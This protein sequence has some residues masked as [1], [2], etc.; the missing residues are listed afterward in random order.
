[1][2]HLLIRHKVRD[3][4]SWK[5]AFDAHADVRGDF[6]C[7]GGTIYRSHIDPNDV[8]LLLRWSSI[9][10][11]ER[12]VASTELRNAMHSAGVVGDPQVAFLEEVTGFAR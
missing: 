8:T 4:T 2:I 12:F 7:L 9:E 10:D 5:P 11:A 6:G 1:M 3:Y